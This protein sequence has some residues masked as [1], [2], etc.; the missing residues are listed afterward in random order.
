MAA[1]PAMRRAAR[2]APSALSIF[3]RGLLFGLLACGVA[4][5]IGF[6]WFFHDALR[7]A[8]PAPTADGIV[9]LTGGQGRIEA[10][11]DLLMQGH[12]RQLLI[13]GVDAHAT[14]AAVAARVQVPVS[15]DVWSRVTLGRRATSTIGNADETADWA[16]AHAIRS[17][18]VVTAGYHIRRAMME[19]GRTL[20][21]VTLY[22]CPILPPALRHPWRAASIRL[23]ATEY[24]KWIMASLGL[25]RDMN[26]QPKA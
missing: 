18:I 16:R 17:L 9:A 25:A 1:P 8:G 4:W 14:V 3:L 26:G 2:G 11:L 15:W 23:M 19:I 6:A 10:S 12:G 7:P 24:D 5:G 22:P 13:S 20:P 21:D